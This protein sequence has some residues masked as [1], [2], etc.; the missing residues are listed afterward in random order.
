MKRMIMKIADLHSEIQMGIINYFSVHPDASASA[1]RICNQWLANE[2]YSH[3]IAQVQT[4]VDGLLARGEI[5]KR[6]DSDIYIL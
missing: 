2:K 4:A 1:L 6:S 5:H 3:N